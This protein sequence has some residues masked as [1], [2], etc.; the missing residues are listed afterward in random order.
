[1]VYFASARQS[2][3]SAD[4][5]LPVK[6]DR[7]L[8]KLRLRERVKGDRVA[9]K[10]HLGGNVGY[11]TI[12]PVFVRRVVQAV[13]DGGG[14]PFVTDTAGS[15][16][17][18]AQRGYTPETL[19]CAI[20][21]TGGLDEK[22]FYTHRR[23]Y[24]NIKEWRLGG[25]IQD[26]TFLVDL[27]HVK[28][29]PSCGFGAAFK[30]L[31]LGGMMGVTRGAIH[32]TNHFDPYWFPDKCPDDETRRKI[33]AACPFDCLVEDKK[34][35]RR[36][37][38]HYEPC[39]Q[40]GRCLKVAPEGSLEIRKENFWAFQEACAISTQIVLSTFEP[41]KATFINIANQITPVCDCFGFTGM[42]VLPD[43]GIFGSDDIVAADTA[44]L[45]AIAGLTVDADALPLDMEAQPGAGH[46]FQ[47]I[48]GPCKDPYLVCRYGEALGLGSMRYE[49]INV[50][51]L[52]APEKVKA[53]YIPAAGM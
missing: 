25:A 34:D 43:L 38:L 2:K 47:V 10:M 28:G 44:T 15:V 37:H 36:L 3:L 14:K 5:T 40:C 33:M 39:N 11:S 21:P 7:I 50:Q 6:L 49:L 30:N 46:P 26:A 20:Y 35:P 17:S 32:D 42:Y 16:A 19:G 8:E 45:D 13:K 48:H 4:E 24:K 22:Y 18:A 23:E 31:A 12:H 27:A 53:A 52:A 9:I 29:H 1:M 41:A 51:P